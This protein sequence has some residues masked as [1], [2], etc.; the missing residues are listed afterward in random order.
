MSEMQPSQ[1]DQPV[2]GLPDESS[3]S[4]IVLRVII[5]LMAVILAV[6]W[7]NRSGSSPTGPI[8]LLPV[9]GQVPDFTLTSQSGE[10]VGLKDLQG[11]VW[12]ADFIFTTC[13][14]P[15]PVLTLRMRSLH[16]TLVESGRNVK[17]VSI[18]VDPETDT[19]AVLNRY[20]LKN[21]A[22]PKHWWFL[23]D[24]SETKVH[25]LVKTGFLQA[26]MP[27]TDGS[28]YIHSQR[29]VL[30]DAKGQIRAHY[31]GMDPT[32]KKQILHDIDSLIVEAS[33]L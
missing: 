24:K 19:P 11:G 16:K 21:D 31:D 15:C 28:R 9:Y 3:G 26:I 23:T 2:T 12:V 30:I 13:S 4:R 7:M 22:D 18:T 20:A 32:T 1:L 27:T 8:S 10:Q 17:C 29:F 33:G 14:G 6:V 5:I 25:E